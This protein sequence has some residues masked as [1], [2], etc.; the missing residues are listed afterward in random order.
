MQ[1]IKARPDVL[2]RPVA[3]ISKR[4]VLSLVDDHPMK[5]SRLQDECSDS[6][7]FETAKTRFFLKILI[8]DSDRV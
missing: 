1:S 7:S 2:K 8:S 3:V 4:S 5:G 6:G